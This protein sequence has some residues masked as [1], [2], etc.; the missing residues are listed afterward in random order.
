MAVANEALLDEMA[1]HP[2]R[3]MMRKTGLS[4]H[5]LEAIRNRRAVRQRTLVIARQKLPSSA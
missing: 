5:T 1:K 4:Q 3:E 2:L